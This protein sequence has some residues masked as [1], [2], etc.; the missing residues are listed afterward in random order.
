MHPY[1]RQAIAQSHI[2]ELARDAERRRIGARS[3]APARRRRLTRRRLSLRPAPVGGVA[4]A[5][6]GAHR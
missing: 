5:T 4:A 6:T 3:A 2:D 1:L